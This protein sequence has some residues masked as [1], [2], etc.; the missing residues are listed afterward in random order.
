MD[1]SIPSFI[2]PCGAP[3]LDPSSKALRL[4]N[5]KSS[6]VYILFKLNSLLQNSLGE[7][8]VLG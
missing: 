3:T 1:D 7:E 6:D 4:H 5:K 8:V 2:F